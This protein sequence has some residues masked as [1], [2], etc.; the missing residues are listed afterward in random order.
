MPRV[1]SCAGRR[2]AVVA[3]TATHV[4]GWIEISRRTVVRGLYSMSLSKGDRLKRFYA[5]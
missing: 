3:E 4:A 2:R 1:L 5:F